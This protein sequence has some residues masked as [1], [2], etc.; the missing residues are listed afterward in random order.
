MFIDSSN[1]ISISEANQDFSK[2]TQ[3]AEEK[4]SVL[5]IKNNKP[6]YL[7]IDFQQIDESETLPD[8]I[9][10]DISNDFM[11]KNREAYRVLA[12]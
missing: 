1:T 10:Y 5:I 7:L 6:K 8:N 9:V 3:M 2:V 12:Q 11:V 4:G